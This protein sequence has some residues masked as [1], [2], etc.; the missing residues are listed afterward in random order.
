MESDRIGDLTGIDLLYSGRHRD[1]E[2]PQ[3]CGLIPVGDRNRCKPEYGKYT[4]E[5][6]DSD[7][8][9]RRI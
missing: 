9:I 1:Q 4:L 6:R 7:P 2:M 5:E 8:N 3:G